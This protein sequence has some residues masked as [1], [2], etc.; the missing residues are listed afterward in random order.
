MLLIKYCYSAPLIVHRIISK[1]LS[2]LIAFFGTLPD[3][4]YYK[5]LAHGINR[6]DW[7]KFRWAI[8][9]FK[10]FNILSLPL[11]KL[12]KN[13]IIVV[14][15]RD[16]T[17]PIRHLQKL[18]NKAPNAAIYELNYNSQTLGEEL[19]QIMKQELKSNLKTSNYLC[20]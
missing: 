18:I 15:V 5:H 4:E 1:E 7:Q 2:K 14:P 11:Y 20:L 19:W 13:T 8:K 16:K 10:D 17:H 6:L 12:Q 3:I 9:G